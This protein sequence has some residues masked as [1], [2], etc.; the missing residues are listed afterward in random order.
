MSL[1]PERR[2]KAYENIFKALEQLQPL[3]RAWAAVDIS[4]KCP[5]LQQLM[6]N[7]APR[8]DTLP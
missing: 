7:A 5:I 3:R 8:R 6:S 1:E 2:Q 4:S